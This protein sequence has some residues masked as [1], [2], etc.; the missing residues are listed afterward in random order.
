MLRTLTAKPLAVGFGLSRPA[1]VREIASHADGVVVGSAV[2]NAYAGRR[3]S[4]AANCAREFV[5]P[6]IVATRAL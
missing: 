2:I 5:A 3:G 6:L 4:E 1:E